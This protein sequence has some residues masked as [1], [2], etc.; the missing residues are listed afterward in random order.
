MSRVSGWWR[1][2]LIIAIKYGT[3]C[4][5]SFS[6]E[7]SVTS[8]RASPSWNPSLLTW[9]SMGWLGPS[10]IR[11]ESLVDPP[12]GGGFPGGQSEMKNLTRC[13]NLGDW[14]WIRF[15]AKQISLQNSEQRCHK[16][17][18]TIYTFSRVLGHMWLSLSFCRVCGDRMSL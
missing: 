5:W 4:T 18:E 9:D 1:S 15:Q 7:P 13:A 8:S 17:L 14:D 10:G 3:G 16:G 11:T 12:D 6:L 2:C